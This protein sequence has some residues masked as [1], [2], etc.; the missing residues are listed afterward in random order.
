MNVIVLLGDGTEKPS[1]H[2]LV[3]ESKQ[4]FP[5]H[6]ARSYERLV[7]MIDVIGRHN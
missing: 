1:I 2:V 3:G 5:I 4:D 7:Q 6:T